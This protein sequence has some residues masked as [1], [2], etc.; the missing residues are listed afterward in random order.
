MQSGWQKIGELN[1][2]FKPGRPGGSCVILFHGY[3]ADAN[4]LY[5]LHEYLG[6]SKN[7]S[8]IF[9]QGPQQVVLGPGMAGRAWFNIDIAILEKA[10]MAG[11]YRDMSHSRPQG[12]DRIQK[13]ALSMFNECKANFSNVVLGGFS[14]GAMLA[15][16]TA[17]VAAEKPDALVV[18][19]GTLL[20][21]DNWKKQAKSCQGLPFFQSHGKNDALLDPKKAE[22]LFEML[23]NAGLEG[24]FE[25]FRGGHEIPPSVLSALGKFLRRLGIL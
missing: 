9:P 25:I 3:G 10:M 14:Q 8:W 18:L 19:S 5:P 4:D 16:Q 21:K 1:C 22:E 12:L 20:D 11:S 6:L 2:I 7:V 24:Q 13:S 17:L 23:S 15:T